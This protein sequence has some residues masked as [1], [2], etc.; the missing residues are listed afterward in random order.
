MGL[1]PDAHYRTMLMYG[2][3][4]ECALQ[5]NAELCMNCSSNCTS[6]AINV[7]DIGCTNERPKV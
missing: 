7:I 3:I 6:A 2:L 4:L 1:A 5:W